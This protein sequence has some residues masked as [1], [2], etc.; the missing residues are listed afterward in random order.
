MCGLSLGKYLN[1]TFSQ[2]YELGLRKG[3]VS[4]C[5]D[6]NEEFNKETKDLPVFG[7]NEFDW[8]VK[9]YKVAGKSLYKLGRRIYYYCLNRRCILARRP[10]L[11]LETIRVLFNDTN[12]D[13]AVKKKVEL[14]ILLV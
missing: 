11:Q 6:C 4:R 12:I 2:C 13:G 14:K 5:T 1:L 7:R 9:I 8:Y 3:K 10:L